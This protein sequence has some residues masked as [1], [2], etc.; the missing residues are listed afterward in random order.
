MRITPEQFAERI[1]QLR[2]IQNAGEIFKL[3][4]LMS[5]FKDA[6]L[7]Y[8]VSYFTI[9]IKYGIVV[10][11]GRGIYSLPSEPIYV[12]VIKTALTEIRSYKLNANK[13]ALSI[14]NEREVNE[15]IE[16]AINFL[17]SNGFLVFKPM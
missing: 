6:N 12:G 16:Q 15:K 14:Q 11:I 8:S 4:E 2:L 5:I 13:K 1:N 10:R 7:P 3:N 9:F 17:K